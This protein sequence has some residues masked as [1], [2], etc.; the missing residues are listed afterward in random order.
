MGSRPCLL[1]ATGVISPPMRFL[2]TWAGVLLLSPM[3]LPAQ[4]SSGGN[5]PLTFVKKG[6]A[7]NA[8]G[9]FNGA[10]DSFN[11]A[12]EIDAED[13]AAYEGRGEA[14]L[15]QGDLSDAITDF[16]KTLEIEP[17]NE[18]AL[19]N[20]GQAEMREGDF[21][22][23]IADFNSAMQLANTV[24]GD[25][26]V[27]FLDRGRAYYFMGKLDAAIADLGQ[28]VMLKRDLGDAYF[29]R[30]LAEL[31]NAKPDAA[32]DDFARAAQLGVAEA[33][34]WWWGAKMEGHHDDDANA[35]LPAL[36]GKSLAARPNPWLSELGNF[37]LQ[38]TTETQVQ[39]DASTHS[40][41]ENRQAQAWFFIGLSREFSGDAAGARQAYQQAATANDPDSPVTIEAHRHL[42]KLL[43]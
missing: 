38:K 5:D 12:L 17:Q 2:C 22:K 29:F 16:A 15:G 34:L 23:S 6:T 41:G 11:R 42:K 32:A 43:P 4:D 8:R 13:S 18:A 3:A 36:L 30:G 9:D 28:A 19:K 26:P 33:P 25:S 31:G 7:Q 24:P 40:A 37:L 21:A 20:R 27:L 35:G 10:L 14:H 1:P 39:V